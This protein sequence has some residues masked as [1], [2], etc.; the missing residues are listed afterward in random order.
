MTAPPA[1]LRPE[2]CINPKFLTLLVYLLSLMMWVSP[3]YAQAEAPALPVL[4]S[5]RIKGAKIIPASKIREELIMPLP[6]RL[7]WKKPPVFRE[8]ELNADVD[9]LKHYYRRQGFYHTEIS[10]RIIPVTEGEVEVEITINEGPWVKVTR[11]ELKPPPAELPLDL[12]KLA[13]Q[14]P[15][16]LGDRWEEG[17]Y[18]AL[19]RVY[20]NHLLDHGYPKGKVEGKVWLDDE[21]NT[22]E[23]ELTITPGPLCYFGKVKI[24]GDPESPERVIRRKVT[25]KTGEPFSFKELY[26]TQQRLY[27]LD[28][29][30]S[31]TLIPE[32][33]PEG[34][35]RIPITIEVE[36][37]KKRSLKVGLGY[38]DE[39]EFRARLGLR[40]RNLA[41]GGRL[42]DVDT[43]FSRLEYRVEGTLF[44][45]LI[46]ATHNDLVFQT[47]YIRRY[48]P[49]FTDKA[50][51]TSVRLERDLPY[52][53]RAY[54]GHG[55]EFSRP[56]NIPVE[57]LILLSETTPG[58][59]Y[60]ASMVLLGVRRETWDN[61]ADPHRGGL[62]SLTGEIAPNF[63]G[64][65]IQFVR[66][67][68]ELRRYHALWGTDFIL[69]GRI[70]A[71][72]I[73]PIQ[74]TQDIPI[75]RRF[76]AGGYNSVRGYRL[77]F[78]G[79]RTPGGNPLGGEAL[80]E[81]SLEARIPIYKEFRA[82]AFLDYGN[83]FLKVRDLDVGQL[84][85]SSG[86]GLRYHTPIGPI[87]VDVG[88]PLNPINR[89][90]DD[91]YRFHFTIGQA[92]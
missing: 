43:K 4:R 86:V 5:L 63:L 45:P 14:R 6:S 65:S 20:L 33:V 89:R 48:L 25:F 10:T 11:L 19:K 66:P 13:A 17:S 12:S 2:E 49:S 36:E 38:G 83:V 28:L 72:I 88:F 76:F 7:P 92:F 30:Q 23:I 56:F 61:I 44:N 73:Q 34:E 35:R 9:R 27:T 3:A 62:F 55:L 75:F 52:K 85:Y 37:K 91:K 68:A 53:F 29:F 8:G 46:F 31:V 47:G 60:R 90:Q 87:G 15:L 59:L 26:E 74:A 50:L 39:D 79:P 64:S 16:K 80:L 1:M 69:A 18:D 78:L 22:A 24:K 21:K 84:K 71:G 70:K 41:G 58:K 54:L 67:V 51:F 57:T 81:G 40:F 82:V 77:D 32:E 42:L